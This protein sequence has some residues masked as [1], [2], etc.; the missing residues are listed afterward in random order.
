MYSIID[1]KYL[2][3]TGTEHIW[4]GSLSYIEANVNCYLYLPH[5]VAPIMNLLYNQTLAHINQAY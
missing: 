3:M 1:T 2:I 4:R 5:T